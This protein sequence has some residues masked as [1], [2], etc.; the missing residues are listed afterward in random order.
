MGLGGDAAPGGEGA[1][2]SCPE[3]QAGFWFHQEHGQGRAEGAAEQRTAG[4]HLPPG[5]ATT[6]RAG[7]RNA[8]LPSGAGPALGKALADP[9]RTR[10]PKFRLSIY[11]LTE[12]QLLDGCF[13]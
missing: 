12:K 5:R 9:H 8:E 3:P 2:L 1:Q 10:Q 7:Q 6:L 4:R 11:L 13:S